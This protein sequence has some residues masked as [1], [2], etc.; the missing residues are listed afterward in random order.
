MSVGKLPFGA[1]RL[2]TTVASSGASMFPGESTPP[3]ADW[4]FTEPPSGLMSLSNVVLTSLAVSVRL[5]ALRELRLELE[6]RI[7]EREEL[8]RR[9][10]DASAAL[11]L[12]EQRVGGRRRLD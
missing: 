5:P 7:R 4:A 9:S 12:H 8:T 2:K 3:S 10:E 11:V 1:S 6:V